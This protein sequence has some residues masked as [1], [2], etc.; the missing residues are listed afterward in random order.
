[1]ILIY[2]RCAGTPLNAATNSLKS[3]STSW[4]ATWTDNSV[5]IPEE[6]YALK[7]VPKGNSG[8][9]DAPFDT[10]GIARGQNEGTVSGLSPDTEYDCYVIA[11]NTLGSR[12]SAKVEYKSFKCAC[13][14]SS[15]TNNFD[16]FK[17]GSVDRQVGGEDVCN[18]ISY[19]DCYDYWTV[20]DNYWGN[21]A[22]V[23]E[24]NYDEE[25]EEVNSE[26]VWRISNAQG[27]IFSATPFSQAL[28]DP[29]GETEAYTWNHRSTGPG[30]P[31]SGCG[32][33]GQPPNTQMQ[34]SALQQKASSKCFCAGFDFRSTSDQ[35][36]PGLVILAQ[37]A[38]KQQDT[39]NSVIQIADT[40]NGFDLVIY[41]NNFEPEI[42]TL[43]LSRSEWH[44]IT[45][46]IE[47]VDGIVE[48]AQGVYTGNDIVKVFVDNVPVWEGTTLEAYWYGEAAL[49]P[50]GNL[51]VSELCNRIQAVNALNFIRG[52]EQVTAN[53]GNGIYVKNVVVTNGIN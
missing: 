17:L 50:C 5:G 18:K 1:M 31:P 25:I 49:V 16:N 9:C 39:R 22:C 27:S 11:L 21:G 32:A 38:S 6:T 20:R 37:P 40:A 10:V 14:L 26:K 45:I 15:G 2:R 8:G 46:L 53:F 12:C 41:Q 42:L 30:D 34:P 36:Q 52:S 47:F 7:C 13:D 33:K 19:N 51:D 24:R 48:V 35:E 29:S 23:S 3:T 4:V 44:R 43:G 28:A